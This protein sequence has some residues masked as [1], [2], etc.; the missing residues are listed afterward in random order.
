MCLVYIL[1]KDLGRGGGGGGGGGVDDC[2]SVHHV[3]SILI[4]VYVK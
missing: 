3:V 2:V 4:A 1:L